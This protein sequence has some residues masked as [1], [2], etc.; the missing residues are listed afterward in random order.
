MAAQHYAFVVDGAPEVVPLAVDLY[1]NL[2][3][4]PLPVRVCTYPANPLSAD[5][6]SEHG[7]KSISP[8]SKRL[9]AD[10]NAALVEQALDVTE[11]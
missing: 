3:R 11:R 5:L 2:V 7:T 8:I 9:M 1:Q 6:R 4:R 10:C